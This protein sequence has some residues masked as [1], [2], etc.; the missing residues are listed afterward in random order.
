[1]TDEIEKVPS[2]G[3]SYTVE[4]PGK[5]ALVLQSF[6]GRDDA[7]EDLNKVLD[8]LRTASERQFSFGMIEHLKLELEQQEKIADDHVKRMGDLETRLN[9]R[10]QQNG[11]REPRLSESEQKEKKQAVW[12]VEE[13]KR[14][15]AKVKE[16]L[17][18]HQARIGA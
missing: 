1:M 9:A 11:R 12:N 18:E 7:I 13:C 3:I 17:S 5:K 10:A 8:K 16:Q 14:R 2:I 4:L 15:I 6:V